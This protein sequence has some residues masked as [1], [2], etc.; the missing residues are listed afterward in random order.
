MIYARFIQKSGSCFY[1]INKR[2]QD[3]RHFNHV[4]DPLIVT[5]CGK[6]V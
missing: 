5:E 3:L 2:I 4:I 6:Q 1:I